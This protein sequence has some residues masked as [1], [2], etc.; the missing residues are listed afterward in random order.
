MRNTSPLDKLDLSSNEALYVSLIKEADQYIP[1]EMDEI[2][3]LIAIVKNEATLD[4]MLVALIN[5]YAPKF[6]LPEGIAYTFTAIPKGGNAEDNI[7]KEATKAIFAGAEWAVGVANDA[8][9]ATGKLV[10]VTVVDNGNG[11]LTATME[12]LPRSS[13]RPLHLPDRRPVHQPDH[14]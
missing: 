14:R 11:T 6:E 13:G 3:D 5:E 1:A 2:K 9:A 4:D 10:T 8:E 12:S 7:M